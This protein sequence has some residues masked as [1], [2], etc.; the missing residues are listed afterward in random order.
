MAQWSK[1][2]LAYLAGLIDGEG[3]FSILKRTDGVR[4]RPGY[5]LQLTIKMAHQDVIGWAHSMFGGNLYAIDLTRLVNRKP[6]WEWHAKQSELTNL[7]HVLRPFLKV[8]GPQADIFIEFYSKGFHRP[9]GYMPP[10]EVARRE[11]LWATIG[12]LNAHGGRVRSRVHLL[13]PL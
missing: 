3:S 11:G 9:G 7:L 6:Q 10:D 13:T 4:T 2:D 12:H 8:K 5:R 1:T